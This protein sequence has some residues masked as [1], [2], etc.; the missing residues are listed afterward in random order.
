MSYQ[1][2][3]ERYELKYLLSKEEKE[4]VVNAI[5]PYMELDKYGHICI[6]NL[7]F[8]TL[9]YRLIRRSIEKPDYKEKIRIR[10]YGELDN[11]SLVYV[12]IKKKYKGVVYKRRLS[13]E[14][15]KAVNWLSNQGS[16]DH[17]DQIASEIDYFIRYYKGL[18]PSLYL[19][20]EREAYYEKSGG[21]FRITF[22]NNILCREGDLFV[23]GEGKDNS[24]LG[25]E[26]VI[27]EIKSS[28]GIPIWMTKILSERKLYKTSFS[29]YGRS[30]QELIYPKLKGEKNY[31]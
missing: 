18:H 6:K 1:S 21:D 13:M 3:F 29:K 27:M 7:Y 30:Y 31:E 15:E 9:T 28:G 24:L 2:K 4:Y 14:Y 8:D 11:L 23:R 16:Y 5:K 10:S 20:Y 26:K 17:Q 19:S 12:E 25:D 22:D